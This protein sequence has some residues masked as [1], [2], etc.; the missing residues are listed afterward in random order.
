MTDGISVGCI[1]VS[2]VE[3]VPGSSPLLTYFRAPN[4]DQRSEHNQPAVHTFL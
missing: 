4:P 1:D 3:D 2:P